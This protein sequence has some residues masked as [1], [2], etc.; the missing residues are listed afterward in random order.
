MELGVD[1]RE[2]TVVHLRNVPPST[3]HYAQRSG[4]AGRSGQPAL[5]YT[6][7]S[8]R[9]PHDRFYLGNPILMVS[10]E[11]VAPRLD[12]DNPEL[13][14]THLHAFWLS[15]S[16]IPGL[17]T[18]IGEVL[19]IEEGG[20]LELRVKEEIRARL[21]LSPQVLE[22][23][24]GRFSTVLAGTAKDDAESSA[25]TIKA[26]LEELP[27]SF[28]EAFLRW[29]SLYREAARQQKAAQEEIS[30]A[31]LK[32]D[33]TPYR[34]ARRREALASSTLDQ[35]M[36]NRG[37]GPLG[38]GSSIGEFYPFRYLAAEGFLPGYNFTRLPI[39]LALEKGDSID[40]IERSRS[41]ALNEFGP[42]NIVY[43]NG[44]KYKVT[45]ILLPSGQLSLHR[46]QVAKNS[47]YFLLEGEIDVANNDPFT[48]VSLEDPSSRIDYGV[49]VEMTE[50]KGRP[51]ER[52]SCDEEDR[53]QEGYVVKTYFSYP[54][55][56]DASPAQLL[57]TASGDELL[58]MRFLPACTIV[59]V[60]EAWRIG[61]HEGFWIDTK[62]G[63]WKKKRPDPNQIPAGAEPFDPDSYKKVRTY[64][65]ETAD[66]GLSRAAACARSR[67][68]R[69]RNAPIRAA[70]GHRRALSSRGERNRRYPGRRRDLAQY[71]PL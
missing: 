23:I 46:A 51:I 57:S 32:K 15:E 19:D 43:H 41:I 30:R 21:C 55:G 61:D 4:R 34:E 20:T 12:L 37:S 9:S 1:I 8:Q 59:T 31:H 2:L 36:N 60:N 16:G 13:R 71:P 35:L 5:V 48:G 42:E 24:A 29:R 39:R 26:R 54:K 53:S 44:E 33:S 69:P 56:R 11:V 58:R 47:G 62:T 45:S 67:A 14:K 22:G 7:C 63:W 3:S 52:I 70:P 17:S 18:S 28:D 68:G 38:G 50:S 6:S 49:L 27:L 10:G 64:T 40:Y 66:A 25:A 65:T